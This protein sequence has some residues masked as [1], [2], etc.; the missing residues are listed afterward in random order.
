MGQRKSFGE[1]ELL[2][3]EKLEVYQASLSFMVWLEPV[4]Q[5]LPKSLSVADQLERPSTSIPL[6]IGEGN[7]KFSGAGRCR[8]FDMAR[9]SALERA[10]ALDVLVVKSRITDA[11]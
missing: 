11:R 4:L 10:A 5:R 3:S 2:K 8:F 6:N 9:G 7:G 1:P